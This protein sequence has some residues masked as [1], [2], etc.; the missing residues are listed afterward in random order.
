MVQQSRSSNANLEHGGPRRVE[1]FP[2]L[3]RRPV[4]DWMSDWLI[5][6]SAEARSSLATEIC[7]QVSEEVGSMIAAAFEDAWQRNA[8]AIHKIIR[9]GHERMQ[10][11]TKEVSECHKKGCNL[12]TESE[13]FQEALAH[14]TSHLKAWA[15]SRDARRN[16]DTSGDGILEDGTRA[17]TVQA[18]PDHD[19]VEA[20]I[21]VDCVRKTNNSDTC[22]SNCG[23]DF[24]QHIDLPDKI[25]SNLQRSRFPELPKFPFPAE[26]IQPQ[27]DSRQL[28]VPETQAYIFNVTLLHAADTGCGL[29]LLPASHEKTLQVNEVLPASAA[30]DWNALCRLA[31]TCEDEVRPGD[32]IVG[33]NGFVGDSYTLLHKCNF[34][35]ALHLMI[36]RKHTSELLTNSKST[37]SKAG[38]HQTFFASHG[39][40]RG[41]GKVQN[42]VSTAINVD[43][44]EKNEV[45]VRPYAP[46]AVWQV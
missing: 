17:R 19:S 39:H 33:V 23:R 45:P 42:L 11:I 10:V 18:K 1:P 22:S 29:H 37:P 38:V 12:N 7:D 13:G 31:G 41:T 34:E 5:S 44:S 46:A 40:G 6:S 21:F 3:P 28:D 43:C 30:A 2:L 26:P 25:R 35:A 4:D 32:E 8:G 16:L 36:V 15:A 24:G 27:T 14:F 9:E 20:S